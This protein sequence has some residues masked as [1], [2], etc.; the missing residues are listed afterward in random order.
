MQHNFSQ[1]Q[2]CFALL[3]VVVVAV[4]V[5]AVVVVAVA[6]NVNGRAVQH[7]GIQHTYMR[8]DVLNMRAAACLANNMLD[9]SGEA[10]EAERGS[11]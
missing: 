10:G 2:F 7:G 5:V 9:A 1:F 6:L 8:Q 4:F 3:R 11:C